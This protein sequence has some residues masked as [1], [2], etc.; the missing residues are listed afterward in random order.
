MGQLKRFVVPAVLLA[1]FLL[2]AA[3]PDCEGLNDRVDEM[4]QCCQ[5]ESII[6]L[7]GA[8]DCSAAAEAA[9]N[10]HEKMMCP[11][12]CQLESIGVMNG[13]DLVKEKVLEYANRLSEDWKEEAIAVANTCLEKVDIVSTKIQEHG[14][15]M[16]CSPVAGILMMCL[17]KETMDNCP[18][19]KWQN[20]NFCNKMKSGECFKKRGGH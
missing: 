15:S 3:D 9:T 11:I 2:A 4:A 13:K 7:D 16:K 14:Q 18:A 1:C 19:D 6:P 8:A 5:V 17:L 12:Q 10:K 20:T